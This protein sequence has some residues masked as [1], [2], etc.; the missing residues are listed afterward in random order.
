MAYD[1]YFPAGSIKAAPHGLLSAATVIEHTAEDEH[2]AG[3][4]L[5]YE[6]SIEGFKTG[7][8]EECSD[9]LVASHTTNP[10]GLPYPDGYPFFIRTSAACTATTARNL[11]EQTARV[12]KALDVYTQTGLERELD[13]GDVA[14]L[15]AAAATDIVYFAKGATTL[16]TA[17][18]VSLGRALLSLERALQRTEIPVPGV[19]HVPWGI[20]SVLGSQYLVREDGKLFTHAGTRVSA[21][22][23][24]ITPNDETSAIPIYATGAI[25]V[26]LGTIEVVE[27]DDSQIV[28]PRTNATV[29]TAERPVAITTDGGFCFKALINQTAL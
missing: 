27:T 21:G 13:R 2:W 23:G 29:I 18:P 7:V 14:Q 15:Q 9:A 20:A 12:K 4:S 19:I 17:S 25:T 24:Y 28:N 11:D 8:L 6:R 1:G 26:H 5:T 22:A 10:T 3:G 16:V